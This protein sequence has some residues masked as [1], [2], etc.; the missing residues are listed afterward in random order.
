MSQ[1]SNEPSVRTHFVIA[2]VILAIG[3][4]AIGG[5]LFSL[6]CIWSAGAL[7]FGVLIVRAAWLTRNEGWVSGAL[8]GGLMTLVGV[9]ACVFSIAYLA[10]VTR[11]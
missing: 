8:F 6:M 3:S 5:P 1:D 9:A 4:L 2:F 10:A 11:G 7:L